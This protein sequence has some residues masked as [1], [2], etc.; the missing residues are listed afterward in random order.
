M[1]GLNYPLKVCP[2]S[3]E[4]C[5]EVC[6][7]IYPGGADCGNGKV[8][9]FDALEEIDVILGI[10][11]HSDCQR[12]KG[13]VPTSTPPDCLAPDGKIDI[14]DVTVVI[15]SILERDNCCNYIQQ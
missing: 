14:F 15:D 3:G 8:D 10:G 7:D 2:S 9:I 11:T 13:D 12:T 6:G 1:L 5:L 4:V